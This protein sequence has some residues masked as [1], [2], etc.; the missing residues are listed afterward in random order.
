M[1][2][3]CPCKAARFFG[4][5]PVVFTAGLYYLN[6][7]ITFNSMLKNDSKEKCFYCER[8][9]NVAHY[10]T[11]K[12]CAQTRD[13]IIP[14]S[15]GGNNKLINMVY[16]CAECNH[17]KASL[18]LDDF[19]LLVQSCIDRGKTYKTIPETRLHLIIKKATELKEYVEKKG[20]LL[21]VA[22]KDNPFVD[23]LPKFPTLPTIR[24]INKKAKKIDNNISK[25]GDEIIYLSHQTIEQFE[26]RKKHGWIV[27]ELLTEPE[28]NFH[29]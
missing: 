11:N 5:R 4:L 29:E 12:P 3:V 6:I 20:D 1:P 16:A 25:R 23:I 10:G 28:P 2:R 27:A 24:E 26:L 9:F 22:E 17:L 8:P 14:V 19:V 15:F 21:F 7:F 13:H 18:T